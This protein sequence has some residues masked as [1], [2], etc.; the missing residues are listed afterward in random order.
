MKRSERPRAA[1]CLVLVDPGLTP[2]H[3]DESLELA[4]RVA[5]GRVWGICRS[6]VQIPVPGQGV[7]GTQL[8]VQALPEQTKGQRWTSSSRHSPPLQRPSKTAPLLHRRGEQVP[9][10]SRHSPFWHMRQLP[11]QG[12]TICCRHSPP[13]QR[14]SKMLPPA[15]QVRGPQ[16]PDLSTQAPDW[17]S[18]Q[19]PEHIGPGCPLVVAWQRL[20]W[21]VLQAPHSPSSQ[22][23]PAPPGTQ[24]LPHRRRPCGHIPLQGASAAM[25]VLPQRRPPGQ[26]KSQ[27]PSRQTARAPSG[28][29]Q[30]VQRSPQVSTLPLSAHLSSHL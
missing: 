21:Q 8:P 29:G 19:A 12:C 3:P 9:L 18:R 27:L 10:R 30:R 13:P 20:P 25:Q 22:Q 11:V 2:A 6:L 23:V 4:A 14:P 7:P 28:S 5:C 17:H 1:Q 24:R 15:P 16:L 26:S